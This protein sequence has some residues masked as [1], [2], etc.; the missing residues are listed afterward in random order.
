MT[1]NSVLH[2]IQIVIGLMLLRLI[3]VLDESNTILYI[4]GAIV[5][6]IRLFQDIEKS[7]SQNVISKPERERKQAALLPLTHNGK[8]YVYIE[9]MPPTVR[10]KYDELIAFMYKAYPDNFEKRLVQMGQG[11]IVFRLEE[12]QEMKAAGLI[13]DGEYTAT[14]KQLLTY[15][16]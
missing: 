2:G 10:R 11:N 16:E 13:G 1:K 8:R 12:A 5:I 3:F 6:F 7:Q 4:V 14:Q 9:D 15:R